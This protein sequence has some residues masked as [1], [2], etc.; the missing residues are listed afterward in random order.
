MILENRIPSGT[1]C[2]ASNS[3]PISRM[4]LQFILK[5]SSVFF[6]P[7]RLL[8]LGGT[9]SGTPRS[10]LQRLPDRSWSSVLIEEI[11]HAYGGPC[12]APLVFLCARESFPTNT[13]LQ[14]RSGSLCSRL[15]GVLDLVPPNC[16]NTYVFRWVKKN[17]AIFSKFRLRFSQSILPEIRLLA[18]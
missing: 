2:C 3:F 16:R 4:K 5:S 7:T 8:Q 14:E 12:A 10:R 15:R 1:L 6:N 13:L 9:R 18:G 17:T 11:S